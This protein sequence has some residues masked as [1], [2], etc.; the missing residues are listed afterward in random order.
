MPLQLPNAD[1]LDLALSTAGGVMPHIHSELLPKKKQKD[2]GDVE[3]SHDL[4]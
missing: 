2:K 3:E 1:S 4:R